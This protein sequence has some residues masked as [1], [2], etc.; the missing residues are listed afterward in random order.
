[1]HRVTV[2]KEKNRLYL[3]LGKIDGAD[4]IARVAEAIQVA[5]RDLTPGFNCLNDMRDYELLDETQE[6]SIRQVQE[7]LIQAGLGKVVRVVRKFGA[8]GHLQ[9][10]KS[11]MSVGYH[12]RSVNSIEEATAILDAER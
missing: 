1:M 2:D 6:A 3:T 12:A 8:W 10:D 5:C 9:F 7:F 11:S 4:E